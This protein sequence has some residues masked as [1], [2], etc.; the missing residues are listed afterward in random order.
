MKAAAMQFLDAQAAPG[1]ARARHHHAVKEHD[2][3]GA[4]ALRAR[5]SP[6]L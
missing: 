4:E 2:A 3:E 1:L 6:I 5:A